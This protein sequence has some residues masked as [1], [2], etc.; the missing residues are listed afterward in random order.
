MM[1]ILVAAAALAGEPLDVRGLWVADTAAEAHRPTRLTWPGAGQGWD[2]GFLADAARQPLQEV[3]E[4]GEVVP[5]VDLMASA[6]LYG[7]YTW[8]G[9][10]FSAALPV[11]A[12]GRDSNGGFAGLGD[13]QVSVLQPIRPMDPGKLGLGLAATGWIPTGQEERWSGGPGLGAG[14][15]CAIGQEWA[16][17]GWTANAGVRFG[18]A[19]AARN[20]LSGAGPVGGAE[21]HVRV[22]DDLV[23]GVEAVSQGAAGFSAIPLEVGVSARYRHPTG[24]FATVG[25][26]HGLGGGVG[27]SAGRL[28]LSVGFGGGRQVELPPPETIVVPVMVSQHRSELRIETPVAE[29][30]EDKIVLYQQIFFAEGKASLLDESSPVLTA[31]LD[32]IGDNPDVTHL[33]VEGHTNA[34]GSRSYNQRLSEA[35]AAVVGDWLVEQGLPVDMIITRGFGEDRPLIDD[36]NPDAMTI[37]RRVEFTVLSGDAEQRVPDSS[38]IPASLREGEQ[39]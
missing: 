28:M 21:G 32:I 33:L 17:T 3:T 26:A 13:A 24:G 23:I 37:N 1:L 2:A 31:V 12:Y 9:R 25:A 19:E 36:S 38:E 39:P 16:R 22:F 6:H 20:L 4:S 15:V 8:R 27:A 14:A 10:R 35:R 34:R 29:L 5:V 7:G 30:V 11:T 18:Q